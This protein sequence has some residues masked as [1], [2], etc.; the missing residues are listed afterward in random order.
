MYD[1]LALYDSVST[2]FAIWSCFL[3]IRLTRSLRFDVA[4]LLG[5][6]LG[7]GM[8]NKSSGFLSLY[9]LP[10][11]LLLIGLNPKKPWSTV[12]KWLV[13]I[14]IAGCISQA[15]YLVLR[16]SP[17][18]YLIGQKDSI[19][20]HPFSDIFKIYASFLGNLHG[21]FDWF[22][23]YLTV[24]I[25][26]AML[27][28]I[29]I[30]KRE[31]RTIVL[32]WLWSLTPLILLAYFGKVL[33]PRYIL[34]MVVPL[35]MLS[36]I[37]V[38]WLIKHWHHQLRLY[39]ILGIILFFPLRASYSI[40]L[41][42]TYAPIPAADRGQLIDDWPSGWGIRELN[43]L[44]KQELAKGE[45]AVFTDGTFGLLPYAVE[46]Y[47]PNNPDLFV[48]GLWPMPKDIPEE[49]IQQAKLK[50]TFIIMNQTRT[51]LEGWPVDL[52]AKYQKGNNPSVSLRIFQVRNAASFAFD[53]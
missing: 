46:I 15:I 18:Y 36:A 44:L 50:K 48:K 11:T 43:Q 13:L 2:M 37:T 47:F 24:P 5:I 40:M 20:V 10:L 22:I 42:P 29:I 25:V 39:V 27:P 14:I 34:F 17:F 12:G 8:I 52:I 21:L 33:Y 35:L 30:K 19:F 41:Q 38:E 53:F 4:M 7:L 31:F 28:A 51:N 45:V 1:R 26:I 6:S 9:L 23:H 3:A 16:L 49:V 32:L